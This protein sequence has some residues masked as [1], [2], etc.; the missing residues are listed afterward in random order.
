MLKDAASSA[1]PTEPEVV[2]PWRPEDREA[3][4][5]LGAV[6]DPSLAGD[7]PR[8]WV[9]ERAGTVVAC[10]TSRP[11]RQ[12]IAGA[13]Q[14]FAEVALPQVLPERRAE[15]ERDGSLARLCAALAEATFGPERDLALY[16]LVHEDHWRAFES[17]WGLEVVRTQS[18]LRR[19]SLEGLGSAEGVSALA[20]SELDEQVRWVWDRCAGAWAASTI[21]EPQVLATRLAEDRRTCALGLRDGQGLLRG[22][23]I[24]GSEERLAPRAA[25]IVDWLV[26]SD[27]PEVGARLLAGCAA[28]ARALGASDGLATLLPHCSAW[29]L[30]FQ[31]AGFEVH[32]S[33]LL[34]AARTRVS[35]HDGSWLRDHWFYTA[36]DFQA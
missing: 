33:P 34:L 30:A 5:R 14:V 16:A 2:R 36:L 13:A 23:A 20:P 6:V 15:L 25:T 12:W 26:P 27:E 31:E 3:V 21:R 24:L 28:R 29:F 1:E 17:L 32:P 8:A 19:A 7:P 11:R 35:R 4:A 22:V 9:L 10:A 18:L